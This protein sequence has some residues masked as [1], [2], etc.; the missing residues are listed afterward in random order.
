MPPPAAPLTEPQT[1]ALAK[2]GCGLEST[3]GLGVLCGPAGVGKSTVLERLAL[4]LRALGRSA[5]VRRVPDWLE[6]ATAL[7][8]FVLADD[9]HLVEPADLVALMARCRSRL[10]TAAL[11]L[12]GEGRLFTLVA[13]D[14][15]LT[16]AVRIRVP[17]LAGRL[18]DTRAVL[19]QRGVDARCVTFEE[20]GV[21]ALH[22]IAGGVP[23]EV[24]RLAEL[25][26]VIAA[27]RP[28]RP[29]TAADVE[30]IH[31]RLSPHAA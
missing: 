23:A 13:R 5:E 25:A 27:S 19:E 18:A 20:P 31:R 24:F 2:L 1:A 17:L 26:D 21:V 15:R 10:P 22:E 28:E 30:A 29:I 12:A 14:P 9:A 8:E 16:Q 7:P 6:P 11:V 3:G 4:D